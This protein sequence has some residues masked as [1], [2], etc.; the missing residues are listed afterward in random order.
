[1]LENVHGNSFMGKATA[2]PQSQSDPMQQFFEQAE[3]LVTHSV[4]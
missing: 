2:A 1:M 4:Q 3:C